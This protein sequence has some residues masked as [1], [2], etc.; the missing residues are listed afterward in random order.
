VFLQPLGQ[1]APIPPEAI[2]SPELRKDPLFQ[3]PLNGTKKNAEDLEHTVREWTNK[4]IAARVK[5]LMRASTL[6]DARA[7]LR[8]LFETT[9]VNL[10]TSSDVSERVTTEPTMDLP[11][12]FF[13]NSDVLSD[14]LRIKIA[15][16]PGAKREFY[17]ASIARFNFRLEDGA[18]S[19]PGDTHFGFL[20]PEPS[21]GDTETIRQLILQKVVSAR[22][23]TCVLLVDFSNPIYS[24]ARARL[25]EYVPAEASINNGMTDIENRTADAIVAAAANEPDGSPEKLFAANW[26]KTPDQ[27]RT[28]AEQMI[29]NYLQSV[30]DNLGK[31]EGFYAYTRLAQSRRDRFAR[32]ALNEFPLLLPKNDISTLHIEEDGIVRP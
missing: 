18:F 26:N 25:L 29:R 9:T 28:D 31:Q 12:N 30:Q 1:S 23:A 22:F 2:P 16:R 21:V 8:P 5:E 19:R 7:L 14:V 13:I 24:T 32:S 15:L 11:V 4:S 17:L 20:V 10:S 6:T 3:R 27:L